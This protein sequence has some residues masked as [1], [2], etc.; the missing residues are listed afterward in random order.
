MR[1]LRKRDIKHSMILPL[2]FLFGCQP[3]VIHDTAMLKT[4]QKYSAAQT[5]KLFIVDCLLPGRVRKLGQIMYL[6]GKRPLKT[7]VGDCEVRGGEY[8]AYDRADYASSLKTWLPQAKQGDIEAQVILGEMYEKGLGQIA[9]PVIA[10]QWY[11]KAAAKGSSRAQINLGHL[12]E[13]GL[14][15]KKSMS[16]ALNWYRK[17]SGLEETDLEFASVTQETVAA[18]YEKQLGVLRKESEVHQQQTDKLR[19]QLQKTQKYYNTQQKKLTGLQRQLTEAQADLSQEKN[20]KQIDRQKIKRLEKKIQKN[21]S[22]LNKQKEKLVKIKQKTHKTSEVPASSYRV[23]LKNQK[24]QLKQKESQY[25]DVFVAIKRDLKQIED[26]SQQAMSIK[27]KLALESVRK[28]LQAKKSELLMI[29]Q[30][31]KQLKHRIENNQKIVTRLDTQGDNNILLSQAGIELIEPAMVLTRGMASYQ[32]R[33]ISRSKK[34]IGQLHTVK[35]LQT[36]TVNGRSISVDNEGVFQTL[37]DIKLDL[38]PVEIIAHY[39][40]GKSS[41]LNFNLLTKTSDVAPEKIPRIKARSTA[42]ESVDFGRFY[43]LVIGNQDYAL[44][45]NLKTSVNDARAV[46]D[47]LRRRYGYRTTLLINANRHQV[48]TAF[49]DLRKMLTEKDNLL[50]YYAGHGEINSSDQS[51]YWL[52]IDAEAN[53]SAN[54]LS[55]HSITQYLNIMEAKHILVV[56][57]SCYSGAMTQSSVVRLPEKM[58]EGKRKKWLNFML[59]RKARTVMT[60]G[61]VKPVL[62]T[63]GGKHSVFAQAF[64]NVLRRNTGLMEDYELFREVSGGVQQSAS[65]I[66]FQQS[67]QYSAMLHAGHEGSPFFFVANQ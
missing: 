8:T 44:L 3:N 54:W 42:Y 61:G 15:V 31:I 64:L 17:A 62:D 53:N 38:N 57:D 10:A 32:L 1:T 5:D 16:E 51:A 20:K 48:M 33:S 39:Q 43:A 66:G 46:E 47:V 18:G 55:S 28:K 4:A 52:P 23:E 27:D 2:V 21:Q 19:Q 56:A 30:Q 7:T 63:G 11:R 65:L 6:T 60:S 24:Q 59:N 67:P 58:A 25:H 14:G 41:Q 50:I 49:N 13:K 36:L 29:G 9:D 26:Q 35:G 40:Q 22:S 12:Y 45:P 37:V 34:I